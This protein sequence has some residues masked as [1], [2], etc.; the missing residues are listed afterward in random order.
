METYFINNDLLQGTGPGVLCPDGLPA[1]Y[2][3]ICHD[4]LTDMLTTPVTHM[5]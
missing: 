5:C 2:T 1:H 4:T 3:V